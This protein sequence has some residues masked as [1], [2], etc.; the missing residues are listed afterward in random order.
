MG[1]CSLPLTSSLLKGAEATP[2]GEDILHKVHGPSLSW[3][4]RHGEHAA[5]STRNTLALAPPDG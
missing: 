5:R 3:L 4:P 2:V 1:A